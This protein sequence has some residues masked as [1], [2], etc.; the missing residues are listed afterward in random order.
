MIFASEPALVCFY[1]DDFLT[2]MMK[3]FFGSMSPS[4]GFAACNLQKSQQ[5]KEAS[6]F[7][8]PPSPPSFFLPSICL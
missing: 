4:W 3:R 5:I 8:F 7:E 6:T 2:S 1:T